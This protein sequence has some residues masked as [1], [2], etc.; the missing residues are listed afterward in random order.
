MTTVPRRKLLLDMD[1]ATAT[2]SLFDEY[3]P[4]TCEAVW[5]I[6]PVT[7]R[8]IHA[9][10]S[11]R[12]MMLHL[13]GDKILRLPQE[14]PVHSNYIYEGDIHYFYRASSLSRGKQLA[15]SAQFQRE[16]SEFAIFY[17]EPAGEGLSAYDPPRTPYADG[18]HVVCKFAALD[19][20]IPQA[21][22]MKCES[23]RYEGLKPLTVSRHE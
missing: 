10:W 7:G 18:V 22:K 20:P 1:G 9:N 4:K 3:A 2:A 14:V 8:S 16:L 6:L 21:F 5:N 11:G 13:E 19:R 12:E 17:G 15:Y 23:A